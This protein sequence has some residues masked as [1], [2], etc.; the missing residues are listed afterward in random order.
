AAA[1]V[2]TG[3]NYGAYWRDNNRAKTKADFVRQFTLAK[4][5]PNTPVPFDTARLFTSIQWGSTATTQKHIEAFDAAVETSTKLL[6]GFWAPDEQLLD[7]EIEA[8]RRGFDAHGA[9]LADLV[10]GLSVGNE[11]MYR[12]ARNDTIEGDTT[13]GM[14][15]RVESARAKIAKSTFA[16]FMKDKPIG[17]T[18]IQDYAADIKGFDFVGL[19][20]YPYYSEMAIENANE[21]FFNTLAE[22]EQKAG[23]TPVWVGETG[24]PFSGIAMGSAAPSAENMQRYWTEVGCHLFGKYNTFWFQL[25]KDSPDEADWGLVD[26]ASQKPRIND[27]SCPSPEEPVP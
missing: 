12:F 16:H 13:E 20:T 22:V 8:L 27:L 23:D 11:D 15:N 9:R 2:H 21:S 19:N 5:L 6:L 7:K 4:N 18:D 26:T 10:I 24:W 1:E 17:H 3:F 25:E 14:Q